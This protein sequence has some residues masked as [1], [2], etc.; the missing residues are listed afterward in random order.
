MRGLRCLVGARHLA[1]QTHRHSVTNRRLCLPDDDRR[2]RERRDA[3]DLSYGGGRWRRRAVICSTGRVVDE[4]H[5]ITN[6]HSVLR[7]G[8]D[9]DIV[10]DRRQDGVVVDVNHL[11]SRSANY[12]RQSPTGSAQIRNKRDSLVQHDLGE[13]LHDPR[14]GPLAWSQTLD[15]EDSGWNYYLPVTA[16]VRTEDV[17]HVRVT[18]TRDGASGQIDVQIVVDLVSGLDDCGFDAGAI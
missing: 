5:L 11:P 2:R 17:G 12:R 1:S 4:R 15:A 7:A 10:A 8:R 9:D 6:L 13:L 18:N 3:H 14:D 16:K